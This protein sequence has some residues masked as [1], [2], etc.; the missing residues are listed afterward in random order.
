MFD[1]TTEEVLLE[2]IKKEDLGVLQSAEDS[3]KDDRS[4]LKEVTNRFE[5]DSGE[6]TEMRQRCRVLEEILIYL[7]GG[8]GRGAEI[9]QNNFLSKDDLEA[10]TSHCSVSYN[11]QSTKTASPLRRKL[12]SVCTRPKCI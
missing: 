9:V 8:G 7:G 2:E 1:K 11:E 3:V 10:E 6:R 5:S 4:G 12:L